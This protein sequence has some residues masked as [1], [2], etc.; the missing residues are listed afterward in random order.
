MSQ[1]A[2]QIERDELAVVQCWL[3]PDREIGRRK[4]RELRDE[5]NAL[6]NRCHRLEKLMLDALVYVE[7]QLDDPCNKPGVVKKLATEIRRMV[8]S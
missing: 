8:Q 7:D 4:L 5:H 6:V 3:W 1:E 2:E